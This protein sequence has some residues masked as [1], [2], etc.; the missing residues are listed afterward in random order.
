MSQQS[1]RSRS[2]R[3]RLLQA[4]AGTRRGVLEAKTARSVWIGTYAKDAFLRALASALHYLREG[5]WFAL[6]F[7]ECTCIFFGHS[8]VKD[9]VQTRQALVTGLEN[10]RIMRDT[11][12]WNPNAP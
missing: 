5:M 12:A 9:V 7:T 6:G 4:L 2:F 11:E 10:E 8:N 1:Y 3:R